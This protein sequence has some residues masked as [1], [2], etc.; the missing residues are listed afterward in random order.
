MEHNK[1]DTVGKISYDLLQKDPVVTDPVEQMQ[2]V[3]TEYEQNLINTAQ[4][5]LLKYDG[6]FYLVVLFKTEPLM[7]NVVRNYFF[8][9]NSC[10]TPDYDQAVY[11]V[12]SKERKINFLWT[13]PDK[14]TCEY[15][16]QNVLLLPPSEKDLIHF[17][18]SF[19]DGS[20]LQLCK[21]LNNETENTGQLILH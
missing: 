14:K 13:I 20:L 1:R 7:P 10:P 8:S 6:V 19:N 2:E 9:R 18:L 12:N 16:T 15:I 3:L 21:Q 11:T 5:G 4:E 17:V